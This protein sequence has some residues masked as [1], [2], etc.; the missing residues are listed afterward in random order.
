MCF[1]LSN[2][3]ATFCRLIDRIFSDVKQKFCLLYVDDLFINSQFFE[4]HLAHL[5]ESSKRVE[6]LGLKIHLKKRSFG[7]SRMKFLGH[8]ISRDD[9]AFDSG[10]LKQF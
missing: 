5:K 8:E 1:V 9:V 4:D 7:K 3:P 6:D 10:K 2:A